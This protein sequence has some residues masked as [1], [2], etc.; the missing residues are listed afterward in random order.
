[1]LPRCPYTHI[2][3]KMHIGR[4]CHLV[5][6]QNVF[7][8]AKSI[9]D[10]FSC[11]HNV[12]LGQK[13]GLIP[14]IGNNVSLSCGATI[15]GDVTIGDNVVIGCNCVVTH[16]VPSNCTVVGNPARIVKMDG[17]RVDRALG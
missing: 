11:L 3:R 4:H 10:N 16:D 14:T 5:H 9:G 1:M 2:D 12:T 6:A 17:K 13:G 7:L 15:I 8:H